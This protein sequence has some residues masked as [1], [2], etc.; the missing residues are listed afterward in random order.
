MA[1]QAATAY[2][3]LTV[4]WL[5]EA[6]PSGLLAHA[7]HCRNLGPGPAV[8]SGLGYLIGKVQ[9]ARSDRAQRF[10]DSA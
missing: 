6:F 5:A 9:V 8:G 3:L 7:E 2:G 1:G 4:R 10:A